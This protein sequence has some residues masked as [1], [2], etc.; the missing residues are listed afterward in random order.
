MSL[1]TVIKSGLAA[2][3]GAAALSAVP[4]TVTAQGYDAPPPGSYWQS[5]RNVRTER[6]NGGALLSAECRDMRGAWRGSTLRF[7]DCRGEIENRDGQLTCYMGGGY[8]NGGYNNGGYGNG[9][10]GNG[11]YSGGGYG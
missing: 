8:N 10:Y 5:C 9:G 2:V 6:V 3:I 1:D 7:S 4:A 11:G